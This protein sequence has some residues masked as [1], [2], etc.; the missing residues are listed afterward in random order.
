MPA[1]RI[2]NTSRALDHCREELARGPDRGDDDDDPMG[3]LLWSADWM[4]EEWF[5]L[6]ECERNLAQPVETRTEEHR[7]LK[8]RPCF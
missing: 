3:V 5:I 2:A 4:I 6:S 8:T 7:R 1:E